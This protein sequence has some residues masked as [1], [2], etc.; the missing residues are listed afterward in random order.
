MV[1]LVKPVCARDGIPVAFSLTMDKWVH[2][3]ALD[4]KAEMHDVEGPIER[5]EYLFGR[6]SAVQQRGPLDRIADALERMV[7]ILEDRQ[8]MDS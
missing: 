6:Q 3:E 4:E 2:L 8:R 7:A 1:T 5:N